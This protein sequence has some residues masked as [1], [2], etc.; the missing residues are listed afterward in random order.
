[1]PHS[2][3]A[4]RSWTAQVLHKYGVEITSVV[5]VGANAGNLREFFGGHLPNANWTG[6]EIWEPYVSEFGLDQRYDKVIVAD[7]RQLD[8]LP[9]ADLYLFGDVLEHMPAADAVAVWNRAREVASWLV[10]GI[11]VVY[12]PQGPSGGNPYEEHVCHWNVRKV[13]DRF[14]GIIEW[15]GPAGSGVASFVACGL[16]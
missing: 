16:A 10:I 6:I 12:Y 13:L 9:P 14:P 4:L 5:D 11:P 3:A 1:M 15:A 8:P 2:D 7:V